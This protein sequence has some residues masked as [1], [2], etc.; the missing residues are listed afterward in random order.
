VQAHRAYL[1]KMCVSRA[2]V[3]TAS[4]IMFLLIDIRSYPKGRRLNIH[5]F[6]FFSLNYW[7]ALEVPRSVDWNG[8]HNFKIKR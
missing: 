6:I 1:R 5:L 3:A 2:S 8:N 4:L 7:F